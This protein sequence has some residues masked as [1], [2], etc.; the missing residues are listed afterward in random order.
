[1]VATIWLSQILRSQLWTIFREMFASCSQK[2]K[3]GWNW[4]LR[5]LTRICY[6]CVRLSNARKVFG[7]STAR[8]DEKI[9]V[10]CEPTGCVCHQNVGEIVLQFSSGITLIPSLVWNGLLLRCCFLFSLI[11]GRDQRRLH[12]S[13]IYLSQGARSRRGFL[14]RLN[15]CLYKNKL[16]LRKVVVFP[17]LSATERKKVFYVALRIWG[18]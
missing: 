12:C 2:T 9:F 17:R 18:G 10:V 14:Y 5:G 1:M 8:R 16:Y 3:V 4:M 15:K 7:L 13:H 6:Y 11:C